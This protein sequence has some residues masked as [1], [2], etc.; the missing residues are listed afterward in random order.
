MTELVNHTSYTDYLD[1]ILIGD[2]V[3]SNQIVQA[4]L[5]QRMKIKDVYEG[6][7]KPSLYKVGEMWEYNQISVA[8][9]HLASALTEAVMN[10]VYKIVVKKPKQKNKVVLTCIEN[11]FHQIGL[12]M[13]SDIFELNGWNSYFLGANTPTF[14]LFE[15]IRTIKPD[16]LAISISIYFHM[17]ELERLLK[18]ISIEFPDLNV[19][20]GGQAFLHGGDSVLKELK[21]VKYIPDLFKLEEQIISM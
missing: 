2:R 19:I 14:S 3:R 5:S 13:V 11:E 20:V 21:R 18:L 12:K 10:D 6:V 9:E 15:L 8:T 1:S 7:I 4:Y 16:F 17:H